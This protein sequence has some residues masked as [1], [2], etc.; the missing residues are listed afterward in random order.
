MT[1]DNDAAVRDYLAG[2]LRALERGDASASCT[3]IVQALHFC[4]AIVRECIDS[5]PP[6]YRSA[7]ESVAK[8]LSKLPPSLLHHAVRI[9]DDRYGHP[10]RW[11]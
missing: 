4:F 5:N 8:E 6:H 1:Y 2:A 11:G 3:E 9:L 7:W 10:G